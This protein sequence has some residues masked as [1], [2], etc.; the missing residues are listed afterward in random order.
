MALAHG[1]TVATGN[2]RDFHRSG[3]RCLIPSIETG[4]G[5]LAAWC[6]NS[7]A[8]ARMEQAP[9]TASFAQRFS[10]FRSASQSQFP[11]GRR[12][13]ASGLE[14]KILPFATTMPDHKCES[15]RRCD[16]ENTPKP[17]DAVALKLSR[18]DCAA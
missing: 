13:L 2:V 16:R 18:R 1:L 15:N 5:V 3:A 11:G 17:Q 7:S 9:P 14:K 8:V 10:G 6:D 12:L 4:M